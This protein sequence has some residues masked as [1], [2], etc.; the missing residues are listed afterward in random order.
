MNSKSLSPFLNPV[1]AAF[2]LLAVLLGLL[3]T[4]PTQA[5]PINLPVH[6]VGVQAAPATTITVTSGTDPD[7]SDSKTCTPPPA[8]C[9]GR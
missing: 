5:A 8:P 7:T 4:S 2:V 3:G 1:R 6:P 9:A